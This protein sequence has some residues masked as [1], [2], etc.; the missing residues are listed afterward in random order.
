MTIVESLT[1]V[2][3]DR[4]ELVA[5][6]AALRDLLWDQAAECDRERRLTDA[7]VEAITA[8]GLM[9]LMTPRRFGG[10]EADL[11][12]FL[13]VSTELGR[14]CCSA[15]WVTGVLTVGNF[16]VSLFPQTAQEQV[17]SEN[18]DARTALVLGG[19]TETIEQVDGGVRLSG[20]WPYASGSLHCE[21]AVVLTATHGAG[22]VPDLSFA[23]LPVE[24]F[25][26][27]DTWRFTGMRGTGSN[28]IVADGVFVPSHRMIPF[29]PIIS[30][31]MDDFVDAS[32]RYRNSLPGVFAVGLIGPL[33][34]AVDAA[35]RFVQE[36]GAAR[37]VATTT[38]P[39]Q[40][41]SPSFQLDLAEA[42]MRL[43]TAVMHAERIANTV[44][45]YA[46]A[47]DRPDLTT[48]AR[49]RMDSTLVTQ[50]CRAAMEVLMSA[51]G[52]SAFS[53]SCPLQ[54]IWRDV[55]TGGRHIAF[56]MGI[57]EQLYGRA[58]IGRDPRE[59]SYLI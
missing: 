49:S 52:S 13:D 17:W 58:L 10:Y 45:E 29:M 40:E 1:V 59:I 20:R 53:E 37:P 55:A 3:P 12:T 48:R 15:S 4:T 28:T 50:E 56:G 41:E 16:V 7:A 27:E 25:T 42:A 51:Y 22:P 35:L 31:A 43:D 47:G 2:A 54:M 46:I 19:M 33:I 8:A 21:W 5:R 57:P 9:R 34:G 26:V 30:G 44:D 6:A 23:L 39:R 24:D 14:G 38:Y 11:K 36:N 32:H 18:P